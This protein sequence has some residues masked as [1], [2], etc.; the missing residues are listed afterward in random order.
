MSL[1]AGETA[2]YDSNAKLQRC[3]NKGGHAYSPSSLVKV[4]ACSDWKAL[5]K[6]KNRKT[7]AKKK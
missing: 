1:L 2:L 5:K 4:D 6:L 3:I 7:T